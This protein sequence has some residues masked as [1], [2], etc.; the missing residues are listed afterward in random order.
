MADEKHRLRKVMRNCR[1]AL[2]PEQ[3]R[4][5]SQSVQIR[6]L[7]L[8]CYRRARVVL[9]YSAIGNEVA[10]TLIFEDALD[11]ARRVFYPKADPIDGTL[12]FHAV[13]AAGELRPGSFGIAEPYKGELLMPAEMDGAV[14]FVP[15]LAFT[16]RGQRLGRGGGFYDRFLASAGPGVSAVGLG[17]SLQMMERLPH[18]PW[19]WRLDY[20]VTE[21]AVHDARCSPELAGMIDEKK[22]GGSK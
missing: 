20:V 5:L 22:G 11:G 21:R 7:G 9:L 10:T 8:D 17:Y 19:D 4:A 16:G 6:A 15:G 3:A 14:I 18:D 1:E 2:P 13:R 12:E